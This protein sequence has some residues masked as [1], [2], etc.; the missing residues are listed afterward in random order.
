M[1]SFIKDNIHER[2][3]VV[4]LRNTRTG[5]STVRKCKFIGLVIG[6][7]KSKV[8]IVQLSKEDQWVY[9]DECRYYGEVEIYPE[10]VICTMWRSTDNWEEVKNIGKDTNCQD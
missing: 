8:K 10:D 4:Y 7:T 3:I 5:S 6:F 2:D 1:Q 9:P